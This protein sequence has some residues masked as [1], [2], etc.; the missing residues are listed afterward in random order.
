MISAATR[1]R[2]ANLVRANHHASG[3]P[4]GTAR[5]VASTATRK[6]RK[7]GKRSIGVSLTLTF[8]DGSKAVLAQNALTFRS[9]DELEKPAR[10]KSCRGLSATTAAA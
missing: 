3:S 7:S 8:S 4:K 9:Y 6:D 1:S 2:P 10:P 5:I